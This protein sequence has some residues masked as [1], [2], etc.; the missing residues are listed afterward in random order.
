MK[1]VMR[2][3]MRIG[4]VVSAVSALLQTSSLQQELRAAFGRL[5]CPKPSGRR[6]CRNVCRLAD[7]G[8]R[9]GGSV[10]GLAGLKEASIHGWSH[11]RAG[12]LSSQGGDHRRNRSGSD[13]QENAARTL[14]TQAK[15]LWGRASLLL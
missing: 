13:D 5:V 10:Q 8:C 3:R 12:Q 2:S 11:E 7:S 6:F 15:P 14:R 9:V 4:F 1:Q